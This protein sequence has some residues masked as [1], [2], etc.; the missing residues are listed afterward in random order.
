[1]YN[2]GTIA[3]SII[4]VLE[5]FCTGRYHINRTQSPLRF[6]CSV[7]ENDQFMQQRITYRIVSAKTEQTKTRCICN[8]SAEFL[9]TLNCILKTELFDTMGTLGLDSGVMKFCFFGDI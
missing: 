6:F 4:A 8:R 7:P 2:I 1:M 5:Y 3:S 9:S